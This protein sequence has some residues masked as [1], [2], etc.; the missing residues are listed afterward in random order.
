MDPTEISRLAARAGLPR[1]GALVIPANVLGDGDLARLYARAGDEGVVAHVPAF[2]EL[3]WW[4]RGA[5]IL[6]LGEDG[7]AR[8]HLVGPGAALSVESPR[9]ALALGL[10]VIAGKLSAPFGDRAFVPPVHAAERAPGVWVARGAIVAPG[11]ILRAPCF[12]GA[13]AFIAAGAQVGP[14]AVIGER[15]VIEA[16]TRVRSAYVDAHVIVGEGLDVHAMRVRE[17]GIVDLRSDTEVA[18]EDPLLIASR[19]LGARPRFASRLVALVA[20]A[21]LTPLVLLLSLFGVHADALWTLV[22][23]LFKVVLGRLSLVGVRP[24]PTH[25][26]GVAA[27]AQDAARASVGAI[28]V[29]RALVGDLAGHEDRLRARAW[30]AAS[31]SMRVDLAL[32]RR[33]L[34]S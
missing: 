20:V 11:A 24:L 30:Y 31:K 13:D 21:T 17:T 27:L 16:S 2:P 7:S 18:F 14:G 12:I 5:A 8:R 1:R 6:L 28:D 4:T 29:E 32:V 23:A 10:A 19:R 25:E 26:V 9:D 33:M 3:P 22:D 34:A 15:A